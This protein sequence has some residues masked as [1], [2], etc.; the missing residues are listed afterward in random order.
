MS[1]ATSWIIH[2][3]ILIPQEEWKVSTKNRAFRYGDGLFESMRSF[4][5]SVPYLAIHLQR[6]KRG[7]VEME[8]ETSGDLFNLEVMKS[9][10]AELLERNG[11]T[12]SARLRLS[13]YRSGGGAY[14]PDS[15]E[16]EFILE[17]ERVHDSRFALNGRGWKVDVFDYWKKPVIPWSGIKTTSS[18][19]YVKAGLFQKKNGMD[20]VL[21]VN[22]GNQL[23]EGSFTNLFV[24]RSGELFTP[25]LASG[26]LPGVMRQVI[27]HEATRMGLKVYE[28]D[29]SV[30]DL[31]VADEVF[32]TNA[33]RGIQWVGAF[34]SKRYFH[35]IA[36]KL[37]H[38][39][40][41]KLS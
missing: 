39:L 18:L 35:R 37:V 40:N 30:N 25:S 10:V 28:K 8:F 1:S 20:E 6:L 33:V 21:L 9:K 5:T 34:R 12:D 22:A 13:V 24:V 38:A 4:G 32:M 7:A 11:H 27:I 16:G 29:L 3:G 15:V 41:Q 23:C 36:D 17:S 14:S 2:N 26:C 19:F 31:M